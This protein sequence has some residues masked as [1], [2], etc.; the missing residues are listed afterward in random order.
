MGRCVGFYNKLQRHQGIEGHTPDEAYYGLGGKL[1][2]KEAALNCS[3]KKRE[4]LLSGRR[5]TLF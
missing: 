5:G 1:L 3:G 4:I 2:K